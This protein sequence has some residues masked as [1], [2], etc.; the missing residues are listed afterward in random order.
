MKIS[1]KTHYGVQILSFLAVKTEPVSAKELEK[2]TGVSSKYLEKV[3][4]ILSETGVVNAT[5]GANGGYLL[6]RKPEDIKMGEVVRALEE[7]N[8]EIID[9]VAK[10][11]CCCPSSKLWKK[12]F[13]GINQIL[14]GVTL[15]DISEGTIL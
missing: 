13:D 9:C 12:L 4:K 1:S 8:M 2:C 10:S 6:S 11:G 14:D 15:K 5:R 7:D 3:L